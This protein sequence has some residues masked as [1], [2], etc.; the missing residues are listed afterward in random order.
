MRRWSDIWRIWTSAPPFYVQLKKKGWPKKGQK[1]GE[2]HEND[3]ICRKPQK[4]LRPA[5]GNAPGPCRTRLAH[6][7]AE[8]GQDTVLAGIKG[9]LPKHTKLA[10]LEFAAAAKAKSMAETFKK[11][12]A[13]RVISLVSLPACEAAALAGLPYIYCGTAIYLLRARKF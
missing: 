3:C 8:K 7:L 5:P 2:A 11:A 9:K 12:G 1:E 4:F 6:V 10:T 13:D